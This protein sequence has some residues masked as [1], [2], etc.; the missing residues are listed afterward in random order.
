[1]AEPINFSPLFPNDKQMQTSYNFSLRPETKDHR[2]SIY[3]Y[4]KL[5]N[6]T[7]RVKQ[8]FYD[9][10]FPFIYADTNLIEQGSPFII[11]NRVGFIGV[12]YKNNKALSYSVGFTTV[13]ISVFD[14]DVTDDEL[15]AYLSSLKIINPDLSKKSF[16][17]VSY[18]ARYDQGKWGEDEVTRVKWFKP[19]T[20]DLDNIFSE[21]LLDYKLDSVGIGKETNEVQLL[22]RQKENLTDGCWISIAPHTLEQDLPKLKGR[23][24]G[25]RQKWRFRLLKIPY[26]N[27]K[28]EVYYG[29]QET[30]YPARWVWFSLDEK[31]VQCHIRSSVNETSS[32][33]REILIKI[34]TS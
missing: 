24:I 30:K 5:Q 19:E 20:I 29:V 12:D 17:T 23:N 11:N 32:L 4:A 10:A 28:I 8:F 7:I 34:L 3:F 27:R 33:V 2:S 18:T 22:Y 31:I 1:M 14:G 16:A 26:K 6:G 25:T 13:E 9:W 15:I 21:T